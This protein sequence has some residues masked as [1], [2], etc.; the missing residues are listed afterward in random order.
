MNKAAPGICRLALLLAGPV[1]PVLDTIFPASG[2]IGE[3]LAADKL[4]M[5]QTISAYL[6]AYAVSN[7][8]WQAI[9]FGSAP[10]PSKHRPTGRPGPCKPGPASRQRCGAGSL[11]PA[12]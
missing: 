6:L 12:Q 8:R 10:G 1:R 2:Q 11:A 5:Q 4:A 9:R 3:K 7:R